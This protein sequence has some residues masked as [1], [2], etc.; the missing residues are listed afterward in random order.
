AQI[1]DSG[2]LLSSTP[3]PP[4]RSSRAAPSHQL[5]G[6]CF[7]ELHE[8]FIQKQLLPA[9][10][11]RHFGG[12]RLSNYR[13]AVVTGRPRRLLYQSDSALTPEALASVDA[14]VTLFNPGVLFGPGFRAPYRPFTKPG[15]T[16]KGWAA[17]GESLLE[18]AASA[19]AQS[20]EAS[21]TAE[22]WQLV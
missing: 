1:F 7:L 4:A 5:I 13:L 18:P 3:P 9:L 10:V 21:S 2:S 8:E 17:N 15:A 11:E 12:A 19:G 20:L 14:T 22:T 6:W 16:G